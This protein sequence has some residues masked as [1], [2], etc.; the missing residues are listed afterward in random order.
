V[1]DFAYRQEK[2]AMTDQAVVIAQ[3]RSEVAQLRR[4]LQELKGAKTA[5]SK[6]LDE[7]RPPPIH[8]FCTVR[9]RRRSQFAGNS[10]RVASAR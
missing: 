9:P 5:A 1:I 2:R 3:L 8:D 6:A 7:N 4:E 10:R